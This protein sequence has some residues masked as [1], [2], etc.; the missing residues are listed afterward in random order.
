MRHKV[1]TRR[2][3]KNMSTKRLVE[4]DENLWNANEFLSLKN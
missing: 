2:K 3:V 4:C 1:K